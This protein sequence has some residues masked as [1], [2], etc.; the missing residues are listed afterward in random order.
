MDIIYTA[1]NRNPMGIF[2]RYSIDFEKQMHGARKYLVY[3]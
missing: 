1:K 3:R 2:Q